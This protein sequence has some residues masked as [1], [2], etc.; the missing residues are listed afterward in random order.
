ME[1]LYHLK[2]RFVKGL[3]AFDRVKINGHT[4]YDSAPH[5]VNVSFPGVRAQV[6]L[7]EL[8]ERGIYISA[9]SACAAHKHTDSQ[10]LKAIG[11]KQ[12][13]MDAAVRFSFSVYTTEEEIDETLETLAETLPVLRRYTRR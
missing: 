1:R 13:Y 12:E 11:L 7:N 2:E 8:A 9:G 6:L 10:T 4:G 3:E 5:I